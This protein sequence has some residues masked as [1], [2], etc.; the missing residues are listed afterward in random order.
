MTLTPHVVNAALA[1][2]VLVVG[3][4][5]APVVGRW[6][7]GA[8]DLPVAHVADAATWVFL[9]VAAATDVGAGPAGTT[10]RWER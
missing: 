4:A 5:K 7:G 8:D 3:A 6:L 2:I 9:D 1:R 10:V